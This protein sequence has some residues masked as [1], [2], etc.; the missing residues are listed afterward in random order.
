MDERVDPTEVAEKAKSQI[1]LIALSARKKWRRA[2]L[3]D[4]GL[5]CVAVYIAI[6]L[7]SGFMERCVSASYLTNTGAKIC[8][9][10]FYPWYSDIESGKQYSRKAPNVHEGVSE[11]HG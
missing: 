1:D 4:L 7:H 5:I 6:W 11:G 3:K 8:S 10:V 2:R 9:T